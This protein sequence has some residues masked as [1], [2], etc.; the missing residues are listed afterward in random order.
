MLAVP[1]C[2]G[3]R[4]ILTVWACPLLRDSLLVCMTPCHAHCG[5]AI[6]AFLVATASWWLKVKTQ[7]LD[8]H[9]CMLAAGAKQH[10]DI[11]IAKSGTLLLRPRNSSRALAATRCLACRRSIDCTSRLAACRASRRAPQCSC[12]AC[13]RGL[14]SCS[15]RWGT[16]CMAGRALRGTS[17]HSTMWYAQADSRKA[18][19]SQTVEPRSAFTTTACGARLRPRSSYACL[20]TGSLASASRGQT[21]HR[22]LPM[23]LRAREAVALLVLQAAAPQMPAQWARQRLQPKSA[24]RNVPSHHG[25][26]QVCAHTTRVA[27]LALALACPCGREHRKHG[28]MRRAWHESCL[29]CRPHSTV[30][31]RICRCCAA[32]NLAQPCACSWPRPGVRLCA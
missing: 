14:S 8:R 11:K 27:K 20:S 18:L 16:S 28:C 15:S 2:P 32:H 26:T 19:L 17:D 4:G 5:F 30:S 21:R 31:Q 23:R 7:E 3:G 12:S 9:M 1:I 10:G 24:T 13:W 22:Q 25:V 29:V 6:I